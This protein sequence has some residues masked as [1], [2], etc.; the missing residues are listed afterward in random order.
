MIGQTISHYRVLEKLGGGG[1]GVVYKAQDTELNRWVA[2]KFLPE[3]ITRDRQTLERFLREARTASALNHPHIC[4]IYEIGEHQG[5]PFIAMELLGGQT[6]RERIGNKPMKV[7]L[8]VDLAI[9]M[10]DALDAAHAKGIVHRDIKPANIYVTERGQAKILDFGLAKRAPRLES[11]A[12]EAEGISDLSTGGQHLTTPGMAL[13]TLAYMSPEQALGE[14]VDART[15]IF[16]LGAVL[17]EMATGREAFAGKTTAAVFSSIL[18]R[19]PT[20][21]GRL[22]PTVPA[23]LERIINNALEKDRRM[24]YQHASDLRTDL[25]RLKRGTDSV[26]AA[27]P[28]ATLPQR[29]LAHRSQLVVAGIS[30]VLLLVVLAVLNVGGWRE[31]LLEGT[32]PTRIESL[33]VLPLENLMGDSEQAYFVD[34]M[35]EALINDLAKIGALRVISRTSAMQY[36]GTDKSLR[37]IARE[38][39]VDAVVEGSVLRAGDR[40]RITAQLI[41]TATDR[42]LWADS[43]ERDLSD[44][45]GL[46]SEVAR[47]IADEIKIK[48]TLQEQSRLASSRSV[49]PQAHEAYLRG[50]YDWNKKTESGFKKAIEYFQQAVEIDPVHAPAYAGLADSYNMLAAESILPPKEAYAMA[51]AAAVKA[52]EIDDTLGEAHVSL[53]SIM[54]NYDWNW[55]GAER[56]YQ[57]AIKLNPGYPTAHEWYASF[58]RNMGQHDEAITEIKQAQAL[59]PLSLPINATFGR[60]LISA[61]LY[62]QAIDQHREAAKLYPK[63][64]TS[65][66]VLGKAY[67]RKGMYEEAIA[68]FQMARRLFGDK[69]ELVWGLGHAYTGAGKRTEALQMLRQLKEMSNRGYVPSFYI[70][71]L[72]VALGENDQALTWLEK[73]YEEHHPNMV[74]LKMDPCL[75]PLRSA[76][77]FQSLLRRMNFPE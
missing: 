8:L 45:L 35:T 72:Y 41:E 46:Q 73:A 29:M 43:Y 47:A 30:L 7:E 17:Y 49:N 77:R 25:A 36:K 60:I 34:G 74:W 52:L 67:L 42:H 62:D 21:P 48:L 2:L 4:T 61:G 58:L 70:A 3:G 55:A 53:A 26:R 20:P 19:S 64:A 39:R 9:Q 32:S 68:E 12:T 23:E 22:N 15:D 44:V 69:P 65:H 63:H 37:E 14:E 27:Q 28:E 16:S 40:V 38:L 24:R 13:G 57:R 66:H 18:H 51:K 11:K 10:A 5:Q 75:D 1:M 76:P 33:A 50:R 71:L 59:D 6:L 31:R 54:E 56:E